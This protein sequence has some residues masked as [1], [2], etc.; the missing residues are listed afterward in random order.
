M[1][2]MSGAGMGASVN[3]GGMVN[4]SNP[5]LDYF[6]SGLDISFGIGVAK[7]SDDAQTGIFGIQLSRNKAWKV[8]HTTSIYA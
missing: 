5:A 2:Q 3:I 8:G 1:T 7:T 4:A 6:L